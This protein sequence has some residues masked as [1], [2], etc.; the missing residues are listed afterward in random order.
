MNVPYVEFRL[1]KVLNSYKY[2]GFVRASFLAIRTIR[3]L[4]TTKVNSMYWSHNLRSAGRNLIVR[5]GVVIEVPKNISLG[6]N[7]FINYSTKITSECYSG[8]LNAGDK[9][10]IS[11]NSRIDI[12]GKIKIGD[13]VLMSNEVIIYTHDHGY[14]PH[15]SPTL[16][17]LIIG[18]NVWIGARAVILGKVS[19]IGDNSIIGCGSIVTENVQKN[20]IVFGNPARSIQ[21]KY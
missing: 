3:S 6:D 18:N 11:E 2:N 21:K 20:T 17:R 5:P 13:N 7:C 1:Q 4:I 9:L 14:D 19:Y 16:N 15:S 8:A 10:W 12:S